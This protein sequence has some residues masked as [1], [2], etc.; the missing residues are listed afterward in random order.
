[1][2]DGFEDTVRELYDELMA[3]ILLLARHGLIHGDFNEFNLMLRLPLNK[4]TRKFVMIDFPQ[5]VSTRH[6]N[7]RF[8][9]ERDVNCV[10]TFFAPNIG[11]G[12]ASTGTDS[13]EEGVS[14]FGDA[15][16]LPSW[17]DVPHLDR[18]SHLD[19]ELRASGWKGVVGGM[20]SGSAQTN[21]STDDSDSSSDDN[22]SSGGTSGYS[23]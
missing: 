18:L 8:Y 13:G 21:D 17:E 19:A 20:R 2:Q 1:M 11:Y 12:G 4:H 7:A 6:P 14:E 9:F 5:M 10:T 15:G 22:S 23:V 16:T 3:N